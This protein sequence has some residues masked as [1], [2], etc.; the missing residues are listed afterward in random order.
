MPSDN[1]AELP[2]TVAATNFVTA[3]KLLPTSAA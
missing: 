3:I 2:V 1:M